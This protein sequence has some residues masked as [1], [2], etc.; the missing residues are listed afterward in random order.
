M[1]RRRPANLERPTL[2]RR[3]WAESAVVAGMLAGF[4]WARFSPPTAA[5]PPT[6]GP[7]STQESSMVNGCCVT[8]LMM[9]PAGSSVIV[10]RRVVCACGAGPTLSNGKGATPIQRGSNASLLD[11]VQAIK[12]IRHMMRASTSQRPFSPLVACCAQQVRSGARKLHVPPCYE[13][14]SV[15]V[16]RISARPAVGPPIDGSRLA[17]TSAGRP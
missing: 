6:C 1:G 11:R 9:V 4:V 8:T 2:C 16:H 7:R 5:R 17:M 3:S 10:Q 13:V 14:A 15:A 12:L